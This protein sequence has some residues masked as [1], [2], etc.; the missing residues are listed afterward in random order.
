MSHR[1]RRRVRAL[2]RDAEQANH[3]RWLVSYAD[4]ITLLFAFFA[5]LYATSQTDVK[6]QQNFQDSI[7]ANLASGAFGFGTGS[8]YDEL[9]DPRNN[10]FFKPILQMFPPRTSSAGEVQNYVESR[11]AKVLNPDEQREFVGGIRPRCGRR[12]YSTCGK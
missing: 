12:T 9:N 2:D 6:K 5:V 8:Q 3:D 11:I 10:S 7:R 4:F 1:L